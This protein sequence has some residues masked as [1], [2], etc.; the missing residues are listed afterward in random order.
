MKKIHSNHTFWIR[1]N[2]I[3]CLISGFFQCGLEI[4]QFGNPEFANHFRLI[5][6]VLHIIV[7]SFLFAVTM[8][9]R[10]RHEPL[11]KIT[12]RFSASFL[13]T[14]MN[15]R[16]LVDL[17]R[18]KYLNQSLFGLNLNSNEFEYGVRGILVAGFISSFVS[19]MLARND[20]SN[21]TL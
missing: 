14:S 16:V 9:V 11:Q 1:L 2:L 3:L 5:T 4:S 15:I 19:L 17:H 6:T 7:G 8:H 12:M 18:F 10:F 21:S 20:N 13:L